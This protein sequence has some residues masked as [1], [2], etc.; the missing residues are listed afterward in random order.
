V[1]TLPVPAGSRKL[2]AFSLHGGVVKG[3]RAVWARELRYRDAHVNS[4]A[5]GWGALFA[6]NKENAKR[7]AIS[8][9]PGAPNASVVMDID[10]DKRGESPRAVTPEEVAR[11]KK[12]V[13]DWVKERQDDVAVIVDDE[14]AEVGSGGGPDGRGVDGDTNAEGK[15]S[16]GGADAFVGTGG[17]GGG[18]GAGYGRDK[19]RGGGGGGAVEAPGGSGDDT[20]SGT[21]AALDSLFGPAEPRHPLSSTTSQEMPL[22][23]KKRR[24]KW[25]VLQRRDHRTD[26][27][28]E[29]ITGESSD[30]SSDADFTAN[31]SPLRGRGVPT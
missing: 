20:P 2:S 16:G 23:P 9:Y 10:V 8:D 17:G 6:T 18:A 4:S 28:A 3:G 1:K 25:L 12:L 13:T 24:S 21:E 14:D 29:S 11:L 19:G 22:R 31:D 5:V 15:G 7:A 30:H 27:N 26:S